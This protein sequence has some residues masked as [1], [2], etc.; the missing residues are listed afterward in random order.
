MVD[1]G[2]MLAMSNARYRLAE[3]GHGRFFATRERGRQ[4]REGIEASSSPADALVLDFLGVEA[5]TGSFGDEL[6][7]KLA[8]GGYGL[9]VE[10]V[11]DDVRETIETVLK[12]RDLTVCK[13]LRP[14]EG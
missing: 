11:A 12:R 10:G 8:S 6:V 13:Y 2:R 9:T 3:I 5:I 4:I 7:G 14:I 1:G